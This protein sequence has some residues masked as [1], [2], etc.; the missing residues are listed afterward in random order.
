MAID[1]SDGGSPGRIRLGRRALRK[2]LPFRLAFFLPRA[3]PADVRKGLPFRLAFFLPRAPPA[4]V[5]KGR[6]P[7]NGEK[8]VD[9]IRRVRDDEMTERYIE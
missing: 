4:D 2:G 8:S 1:R 6:K 3:P 9:T 7:T 5:R